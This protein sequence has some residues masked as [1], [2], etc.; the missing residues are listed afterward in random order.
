MRFLSRARALSAMVSLSFTACG[1]IAST[2]TGASLDAGPERAANPDSGGDGATKRDAGKVDSGA[3]CVHVGSLETLELMVSG[4]VTC[5]CFDGVFELNRVK[6][7]EW[8]SRPIHGCP[9]QTTTAFLKFSTGTEL[10][11]GVTDETSDP[12]SGNSDFAPATRE[13]CSP[14]SISGGG[15]QAGNINAFCPGTEDENMKWTL[16]E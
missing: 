16:T 5:T 4:F 6:S 12:G 1:G 8:A 14:F 2:G 10:G 13:T 11:L 3:S 15:S 9:G 7:N